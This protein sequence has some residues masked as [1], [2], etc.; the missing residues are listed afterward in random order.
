MAGVD[1]D[2][3]LREASPLSCD[4]LW[5]CLRETSAGDA[6]HASHYNRSH[7]VSL[8]SYGT[9]TASLIW[10]YCAIQNRSTTKWVICLEGF[11]VRTP[12]TTECRLRV[13][14]PSSRGPPFGDAGS[15]N[16]SLPCGE[17]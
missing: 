2:T 1:I 13:P 16:R 6:V 8:T 14:S 9:T 5:F 3:S 17:S 15:C 11:Y 7:A 4:V 10:L 12:G